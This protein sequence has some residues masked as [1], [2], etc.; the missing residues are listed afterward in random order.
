MELSELARLRVAAAQVLRALHGPTGHME[1]V[2]PV[3]KATLNSHAYD[4]ALG[5]SE[6]AAGIRWT[7]SD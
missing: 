1:S 2:G 6:E 4:K 7:F 5:V 3:G